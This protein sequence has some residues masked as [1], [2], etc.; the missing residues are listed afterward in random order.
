MLF[1]E[2]HTPHTCRRTLALLARTVCFSLADFFECDRQFQKY[3]IAPYEVHFI[4]DDNTLISLSNKDHPEGLDRADR[5]EMLM[6]HD[7]RSS[8]ASLLTWRWWKHFLCCKRE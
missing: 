5:D 1:G 2:P 6:E 3:G 8:F 4:Q 7:E